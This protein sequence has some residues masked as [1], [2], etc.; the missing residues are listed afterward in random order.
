MVSVIELND[1][2][3]RITRGN[4]FVLGVHLVENRVVGYR[5]IEQRE[6]EGEVT[7]SEVKLVA[8]DKRR[9]ILSEGE[10]VNGSNTWHLNPGNNVIINFY[11]KLPIGRYGIEIIFTVGGLDKRFY[12]EPGTCFNVVES[13]PDGF[14]PA[15]NVMT[16]QADANT[17]LGTLV[18]LSGYPTNEQLTSALNGKVDKVNGKGLSTNDFTNEYK[19][20]LDGMMEGGSLSIDVI[21]SLLSTEGDKPL[22]AN[23][24]RILAYNLQLLRDSLANL[25]FNNIPSLIDMGVDTSNFK[26]AVAIDLEHCTLSNSN[27]VT[28]N[29]PFDSEVIVDSGYEINSVTVTMGGIDVSATA[30]NDTNKTISIEEVTGDISIEIKCIRDTNIGYKVTYAYSLN[31]PNTFSF[32]LNGD[33]MAISKKIKNVEGH[34]LTFGVG[35]VDRDCSLVFFSK[36]TGKYKSYY[37]C[38]AYPRQITVSPDTEVRLAF[39]QSY[40]AT[41]GDGLYVRDDTTG[42]YL[43]KGSE[44][45]LDSYGSGNE[46]AQTPECPT[47]AD[48][49]GNYFNAGVHYNSAYNNL[50]G[51]KENFQ[52]MPIVFKRLQGTIDTMLSPVFKFEETTEIDFWIG[53]YQNYLGL[54]IFSPEGNTNYYGQTSSGGNPRTVTRAANTF[55]QLFLHTSHLADAYIKIHGSDEYLWRGS[56]YVEQENNE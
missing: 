54:V 17:G 8:A 50:N 49:K 2:V 39:K 51:M 4:D 21:N 33:L 30:Y 55:I 19:E 53:E 56:D 28:R 15:E 47:M 46:Y 12:L 20:A 23:M 44:I 40:I 32:G 3:P 43:L 13:S 16:Y 1:K 22:S 35:K 14:V 26:Y 42:E 52:H 18:D 10:A 11:D 24:G 41:Y 29:A 34:Q 7:I 9:T 6:I 5:R 37:I 38:N 25:A 27:P 45:D 36:T 48:D 31:A